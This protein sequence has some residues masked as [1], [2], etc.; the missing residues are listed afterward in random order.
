MSRS[1]QF[2]ADSHAPHTNWTPRTMTHARVRYLLPSAWRIRI[3]PRG[4]KK[5]E[6]LE[7]IPWH[8]LNLLQ[9]WRVQFPAGSNPRARKAKYLFTNATTSRVIREHSV[10]FH[11][12][13][14]LQ[15]EFVV[16]SHESACATFLQHFS[17]L[18]QQQ[19]TAPQPITTENSAGRRPRNFHKSRAGKLLLIKSVK[20]IAGVRRV[21]PDETSH[22][23]YCITINSARKVRDGVGRLHNGRCSR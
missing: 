4:G 5:K 11:L 2:S 6:K 1:A 19:L 8:A 12:P 9:F 21:E 23:S 22:P 15:T 17:K 7:R 13:S 20:F 10:S 18:I 14:V 3:R 16:T